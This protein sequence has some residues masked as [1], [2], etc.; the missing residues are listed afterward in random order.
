M[1]S[2]RTTIHDLP[3]EL[4]LTIAT[5]FTNIRRNRDLMNL[6]LVA[7]KWRPIA[8]ECLIKGPRFNIGFIYRYMWEL[9]HRSWLIG[10]VTRL[11]MWSK[12][13]ER[14]QFDDRRRSVKEYPA[15]EA[16]AYLLQRKGFMEEC[17]AVASLFGLDQRHKEEWL[18]AL[19]DDVIPALFGVLICILPNLQELKL[20]NAW[21]MDCPFFSAMFFPHVNA[22]LFAPTAWKHT[23]LTGAVMYALPRFQV[24]EVP[25]DLT[26]MQ[27]HYLACPVFNF[28]RFEKLRELGISM[29]VL[30]GFGRGPRATP[31][32]EKFLPKTLEVLRI[33]EATYSTPAF[34][35]TVCLAKKSGHFPALR[36]LEVYF[37]NYF[38]HVD[39][40]AF[41][42][43]IPGPIP[44]MRGT[45]RDAGLELYMYFP[46]W[47]MKTWVAGRT[48]WNLK[49]NGQAL[50]MGEYI[51]F[52]TA[53]R[54]V[55]K[56]P[57]FRRVEAEWDRDGDAVMAS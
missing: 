10:Q 35:H 14:V 31:I 48:P 16:P 32:P 30:H 28:R 41:V 3:D 56:L 49:E 25:T 46:P 27:F 43:Q 26:A 53:V 47:E 13:Q 34:V 54:A 8:Q 57:F 33:S 44:G 20:G 21:L 7:K 52:T 4:L 19:Q 45:C 23:F 37:A 12:S 9:G 5:Q 55:G 2:P 18:A 22:Q 40:A 29:K 36:R 50:L 51:C 39:I 38:E 15:F 6:A 1:A 24:L 42:Y 17:A 11:E